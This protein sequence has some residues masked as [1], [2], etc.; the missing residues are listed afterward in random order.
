MAEGNGA[1]GPAD[2]TICELRDEMKNDLTALKDDIKTD[3]RSEFTTY[4]ADINCEL[5]EQKKSIDEI[6]TQ[7]EHLEKSNSKAYEDL[8]TTQRKLQEKITKLEI[9]SRG[10]NVRIF[11]V[12]EGAENDSICGFVETL[13]RNELEGTDLRIQGAQRVAKKMNRNRETPRSIVV[14]FLQHHVKEMILKKAWQD[15][16]QLEGKPL[17]FDH[18]Y[19]P[20]VVQKRETYRGIKK[21]LKE[22]G[23]RFQTPLTRIKIHWEEGPK[24]YNTAEEAEEAVRKRFSSSDD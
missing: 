17:R 18:D 2:M 3:F 9:Q 16:I 22:K 5:Q 20:E 21:V 6:R 13:L 1:Q 12:P 10:N 14:T 8:S 11:G 7:I 15:G 4:K 19:P 24:L 23:I